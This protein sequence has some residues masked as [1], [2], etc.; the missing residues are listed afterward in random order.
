MY[1]FWQNAVVVVHINRSFIEA[2]Y[3]LFYF[4][5][6]YL[7]NYII[8]FMP[9]LAYLLCYYRKYVIYFLLDISII[10][11]CFLSQ[12]YWISK[13]V[14]SQFICDGSCAFHNVFHD[15]KL[16]FYR[17]LYKLSNWDYTFYYT[18][19]KNLIFSH[20]HVC[21]GVN[22]TDVFTECPCSKGC[23]FYLVYTY[24]GCIFVKYLF[25]IGN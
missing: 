1:L 5:D 12:Q 18:H 22:V 6:V 17:L 24:S 25:S 9:Y 11:I 16:P 21:S 15:K 2:I 13:V 8:L 23:I 20:T 4:Q 14:A 3:I 10:I 7:C 19:I